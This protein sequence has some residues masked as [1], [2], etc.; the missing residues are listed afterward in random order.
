MAERTKESLK[1]EIL[2]QVVLYAHLF[3]G[4]QDLQLLVL[5]LGSQFPLLEG[6]LLE[7]HPGLYRRKQA[8]VNEIWLEFQK[9][10][11]KW[12]S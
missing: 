10:L 12:L 7:A 9:P 3:I 6:F 2:T 8:L 5:L 1:R 11:Y 4:L